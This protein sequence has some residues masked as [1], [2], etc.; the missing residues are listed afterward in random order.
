MDTTTNNQKFDG[1]V[2]NMDKYKLEFHEIL[3]F[4]KFLFVLLDFFLS[5]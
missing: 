1:Q 5:F 3:N 4:L 2:I